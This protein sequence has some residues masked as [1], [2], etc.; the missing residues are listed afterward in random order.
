M[1]GDDNPAVTPG[2]K[3]GKV[4]KH[5]FR[6]PDGVDYVGNKGDNILMRVEIPLDEE[7]FFGR[8]CPSCEQV[9]RIAHDDYEALPDD[10]RLWCVY[11]GH[12]DDHNEFLTTQQKERILRPATDI[13][14]QL[15]GQMFDKSFGGL[16]RR[17]RGSMISFSYRSTPYYPEPLPD[18]DE[19]RLVRERSC[20]SC[21]LRYAVF[22]EHRFCP[23]CGPL[24]PG[25]VA[26]DAIAA[27]TARL[28]VLATLPAQSVAALREQGVFD[29]IYVD[30]IE[31]LV[32]IVESLASSTFNTTVPGAPALLKGKGNVFQRLNDMAGLFQTYVGSDLR[33]TVGAPLWSLLESTW[34]ARHV[35]GHR[36]GIVD[37]RY[38]AN[39][40]TATVSAGQRLVLSETSVRQAIDATIDA[41]RTLCDAITGVGP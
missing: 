23:V 37:D 29:R 1:T 3:D 6:L 40:P 2:Q 35:F 31:N 33:G 25:V 34:A 21:S 20:S 7:G 5:S 32:S 22:G 26:V 11:C 9:F 28:D 19:E 13:A 30:T 39:V 4:T 12:N 16:A 15:V 41:T 27:E 38:L 17:T 10:L 8:Q 18:I 14:M 24:A 36:D